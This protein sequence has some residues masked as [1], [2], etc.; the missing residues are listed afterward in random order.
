MIAQRGVD[1]D[2][3][4]ERCA[5]QRRNKEMDRGQGPYGGGQALINES[6]LLLII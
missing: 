1:V 2:G 4:G 5:E 3:V 6:L